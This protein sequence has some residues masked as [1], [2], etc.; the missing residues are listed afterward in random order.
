VKY[1]E[2]GKSK[3][4]SLFSEKDRVAWLERKAK[5]GGFSI[6]P[7]QLVVRD[8]PFRN[9]IIRGGKET[10]HATLNMVDVDGVLRVKDHERFIKTIEDGIGPAKGLGCGLISLAK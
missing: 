9:F 5:M 8:A 4:I 1:K 3:R 2:D 10:H 6:D 7:A